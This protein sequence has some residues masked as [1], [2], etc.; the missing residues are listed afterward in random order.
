M[1]YQI[2]RRTTLGVTLQDTV[3][4]L[5]QSQQ[6]SHALASRILLQFDRS[7]NSAFEKQARN[8]RFTFKGDLNTYRY[9]DNVWT[10]ILTGVDFKEGSDSIRTSKIKVVACDAKGAANE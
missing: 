1:S 5:L 9:C 3:D 7:M 8:T 6:I 4:Y 2:Y 10:C